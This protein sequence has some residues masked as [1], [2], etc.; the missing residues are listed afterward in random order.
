MEESTEYWIIS[1]Q[2]LSKFLEIYDRL[3]ED[4]GNHVKFNYYRIR[5]HNLKKMC[6]AR[7]K[8]TENDEMI[9]R[10]IEQRVPPKLI[11]HA[12]PNYIKS[13][14]DFDENCE[15]IIESDR[16]K[17]MYNLKTIH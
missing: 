1:K 7:L 16:F 17:K 15:S 3:V 9:R 12:R 11:F 14:G 8:D 5:E 6:I 4:A 13:D 10:V 2:F